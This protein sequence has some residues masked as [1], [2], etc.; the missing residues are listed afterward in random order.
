MVG[1][2]Y[3]ANVKSIRELQNSPSF[4]DTNYAHIKYISSII[5]QNYTTSPTTINTNNN[6]YKYSI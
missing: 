1:R 3:K 2:Q 6:D 4:N 5:Y